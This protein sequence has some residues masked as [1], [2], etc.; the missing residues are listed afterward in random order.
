MIFRLPVLEAIRR[1]EVTL[2]FRRWVRP[3]VRPG[4]TLRT[5]VGVVRFGR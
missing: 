3:G 1:G 5:A 4:G 2:A